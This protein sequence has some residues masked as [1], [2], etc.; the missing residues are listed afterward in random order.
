MEWLQ[1]PLTVG[2]AA[3]FAGL[4]TW[5]ATRTQVKEAMKRERQRWRREIRAEP[6][7]RL[8]RQLASM[9]SCMELQVRATQLQKARRKISPTLTGVRGN[10]VEFATS[11]R[12]FYIETRN[13]E[14]ALFEVAD[15]TISKVVDEALSKYVDISGRIWEEGIRGPEGVIVEINKELEALKEAEKAVVRV[16][17]LIKDRL[18]ELARESKDK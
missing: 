11:E 4:F 7:R 16:Q 18:E 8:S 14:Q 15:D 9:A 6:L 1:T 17:S 2:L 5:L 13:L 10:F 3:L 12:D